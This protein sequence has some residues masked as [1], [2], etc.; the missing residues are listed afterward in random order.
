MKIEVKIEHQSGD[1]KYYPVHKLVKHPDGWIA[2]YTTV[3]AGYHVSRRV[4]I[5]TKDIIFEVEK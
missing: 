2:S 1:V 4:K 3:K 5:K